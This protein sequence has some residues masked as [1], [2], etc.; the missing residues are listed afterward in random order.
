MKCHNGH[1]M[2]HMGLWPKMPNEATNEV[3]YK[4][5]CYLCK[6]YKTFDI[7]EMKVEWIDDPKG[8][9]EKA[10]SSRIGDWKERMIA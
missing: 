5:A 6:E 4:F 1:E 7:P 8:I 3:V 10:L 9:P 2:K